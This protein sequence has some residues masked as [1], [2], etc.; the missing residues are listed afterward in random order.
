[1]AAVAGTTLVCPGTAL[2]RLW[3]LNKLAYDQLARM[4]TGVG[5]LFLLLSTA[6]MAATVGWFKRRL[7][8]W[9]LAVGSLPCRLPET[10]LI[11]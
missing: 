1:M 5:T 6:L 7:W 8:G 2:D 3:T 11:S 9:R 4:G 10:S